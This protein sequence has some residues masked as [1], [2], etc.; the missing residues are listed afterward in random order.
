MAEELERVT[1]TPGAGGMVLVPHREEGM[2]AGVLPAD[3]LAILKT[4]TGIEGAVKAGGV[5]PA[6]GKGVEPAQVVR[7]GAARTV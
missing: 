5:A 6:L 3:Y 7:T 2:D 1:T 4:V